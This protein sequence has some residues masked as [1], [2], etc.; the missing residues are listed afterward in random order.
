MKDTHKPWPA[1]IIVI[2]NSYYINNY[3]IQVTFRL[4]SPTGP[5]GPVK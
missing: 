1:S 3:V 2:K 5:A 4:N